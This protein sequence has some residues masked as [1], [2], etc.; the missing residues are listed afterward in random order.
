MK[1]VRLN[2][3]RVQGDEA[4]A[5]IYVKYHAFACINNEWQKLLLRLKVIKTTY[6][7]I[8]MSSGTWSGYRPPLLSQGC[9]TSRLCLHTVPNRYADLIYVSMFMRI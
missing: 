8:L 1:L 6:S 5:A 7:L 4:E 2:P 9:W 3:V